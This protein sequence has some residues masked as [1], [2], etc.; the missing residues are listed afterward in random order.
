MGGVSKLY[1]KLMLKLSRSM[2]AI[3]IQLLIF[4]EFLQELLVRSQF[5][6]YCRSLTHYDVM[7][8]DNRYSLPI[9]DFS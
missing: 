2:K 9:S 7:I 8:S 3:K 6:L 5:S 1:S 4:V